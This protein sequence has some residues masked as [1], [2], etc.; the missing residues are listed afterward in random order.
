MLQVQHAG[1]AAVRK[2]RGAFFTP[3]DIAE[4][5]TAWAIDG[6]PSAT[7]LDPTCG[8]AVFLLSAGRQLVDLGCAPESLDRQV[9]GI[10]IHEASLEAASELLEAEG[11]DARTVC[12][13]FFDMLPP[14]RL[15][16]RLP[17]VDGVVGN[18]PF[19]RYQQHTGDARRRSAS[20]ALAQGVRLSG[21]AS[22][23]AAALVHSCAFLKPEGRLAMVLP[24][25]LLTVHYAEPIR[26]WL[27]QRFASVELVVFE[28][29]QFE[30]AQEHVVL[31][32]ARGS[33]SCE[34]FRLRYV[35]S[36]TDLASRPAGRVVV[37]PA[38]EG[39][40][41]DLLLTADQRQLLR[42]VEE[43]FFVPLSTY[44]AP[45]LG[46]VTGA[47]DFF[48]LDEHT[49]AR[50]GLGEH[51]L[52]RISP[53]GTKHL[54]GLSL[55]RGQWERLRWE[56]LSV[57]LFRPNASDQCAA[58]RAYVAEGEAA[59]VP[60]AYKCQIRT[61]W[62]RPPSVDPPDL[63]FTYMSHRY[64]RLIANAAG[65]SFLNSMHGLSLVKTAPREAKAALPLLVLNSLSMLGAEIHGRAYG[66]GVLK[67]EPREAARLPVPQ[68]EVLR[69][70]W[71]ILK[72]ERAALDRQLKNG[73][74]TGVVK[75]VDEA[76][77][78]TACGLSPDDAMALH[79]AA[80]GLRERRIG[81]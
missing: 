30:D 76:L 33:G 48:A 65:V 50:F 36:A 52:V 7:V 77:L 20:A 22:S 16:A 6:D 80:R 41:T 71:E 26:R 61:P 29:L 40:W 43:R 38:A 9:F 74:W 81:R 12:S 54:S 13:D 28:R 34:S 25:E 78:Q 60:N 49:R 10:D 42:S 8:E 66:G 44:G 47:N 45:E 11:L 32:L 63:F 31:L 55:T 18:P 64:P 75:R 5:L 4:F 14:D 17:P 21:L 69:R 46:T 2:A 59:G 79:E 73:L 1:I 53:P 70:A 3:P 37:H 72:P 39:K 15:G 51:Q 24:A 57:W 27:R 56:G 35:Q 58:V 62:W 19:V 23:W 68:P 67:M